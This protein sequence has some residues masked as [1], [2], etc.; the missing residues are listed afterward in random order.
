MAGLAIAAAS[1]VLS[2]GAPALSP[3]DHLILSAGFWERRRC[4]GARRSCRT[5]AAPVAC[6]QG[7]LQGV[8]QR[9]ADSL[10]PGRGARVR[11]GNTPSPRQRFRGFR[12]ALLQDLQICQLSTCPAC[13]TW[14]AG[15]T[16]KP[17]RAA[18][19]RRYGCEK[20]MAGSSRLALDGRAAVSRRTCRATKGSSR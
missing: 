17:E 1:P 15:D 4:G 11:P 12:R 7:Q 3:S 6:I 16:D 13:A 10:P 14:R 19:E 2:A 5:P 18:G 8:Q 9:G 20:D